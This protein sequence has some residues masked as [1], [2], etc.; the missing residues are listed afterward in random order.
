M[1]NNHSKLLIMSIT[2]TLFVIMVYGYM[3]HIINLSV[4]RIVE[5]KDKA[6]SIALTRDREERFLQTYKSTSSKWSTLQNFFIDSN[7]IVDFIEIV[8]K[9]SA[10]SGSKV[11]IASIEADNPEKIQSGKE[12]SVRLKIS[13]KGSWTAVMKALALSETLPFKLKINNVRANTSGEAGD[14]QKGASSWAMDYDLQV[15]MIVATS[16]A[17][18]TSTK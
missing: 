14:S 3:H 2:V 11:S 13:T 8:E 17:S 4:K 5:A 18:S 10:E 16:T 15:A 6:D 9:L 1:K 7:K 12:G